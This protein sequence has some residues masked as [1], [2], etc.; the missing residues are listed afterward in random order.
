MNKAVSQ[1]YVSIEFICYSSTLQEQTIEKSVQQWKRKK[2]TVF[3]SPVILLNHIKKLQIQPP[4]TKL[5]RP[6]VSIR[7]LEIR[8]PRLPPRPHIPTPAALIGHQR[9]AVHVRHGGREE[10]VVLDGGE[11]VV[12]GEVGAAEGGEELGYGG[13]GEGGGGEDEV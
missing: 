6:L 4:R 12:D 5:P 2:K 11:A 8:T 10:G 9:S 7:T 13:L 1:W 3:F